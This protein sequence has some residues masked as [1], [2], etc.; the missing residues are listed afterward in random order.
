M[1]KSGSLLGRTYTKEELLNRE[2]LIE[3]VNSDVSAAEVDIKDGVDTE[4]AKTRK[5]IAALP[6]RLRA[7]R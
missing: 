6:K 7:K 5:V 4:L 3:I 2:K 1:E